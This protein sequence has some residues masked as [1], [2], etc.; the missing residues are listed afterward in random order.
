MARGVVEPA[1]HHS[2]VEYAVFPTRY[3]E[4]ASSRSYSEVL[5]EHRLER[6]ELRVD[7]P[8]AKWRMCPALDAGIFIVRRLFQRSCRTMLQRN[9]EAL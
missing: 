2:R 4:K 5:Y 6:V 7:T 3:Q 1:G 9:A 8:E